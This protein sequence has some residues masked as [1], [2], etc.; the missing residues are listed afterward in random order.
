MIH[1]IAQDLILLGYISGSPVDVL[2]TVVRCRKMADLSIF[3]I[4]L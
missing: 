4:V 3:S 1:E 2:S